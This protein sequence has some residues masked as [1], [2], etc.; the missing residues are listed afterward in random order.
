ML[1]TFLE[2]RW[3]L[4]VR[5][6][7][8]VQAA[9]LLQPVRGWQRVRCQSLWGGWLWKH[10]R[11][12]QLHMPQWLFFQRWPTCLHSSNRTYML[13]FIQDIYYI[14]NECRFLCAKYLYE[15]KWIFNFCIISLFFLSQNICY[16]FYIMKRGTKL[17]ATPVPKDCIIVYRP[18]VYLLHS[19]TCEIQ[20]L[21]NST[22]LHNWT[23][24]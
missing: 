8:R 11:I 16:D 15:F 17:L 20:P 13:I 7:W 10:T 4:S 12:L 3:R 1:L 9:F 14:L 6:P 18:L 22:F 5:V 24:Q 19:S 21:L 23:V 2:S